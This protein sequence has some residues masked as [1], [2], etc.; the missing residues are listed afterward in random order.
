MWRLISVSPTDTISI[1]LVER[2]GG[3]MLSHVLHRLWSTC[4]EVVCL[5]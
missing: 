1:N 4:F 3:A 5:T 2:V